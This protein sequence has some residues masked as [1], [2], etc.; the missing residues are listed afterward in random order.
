MNKQAGETTRW[1]CVLIKHGKPH[2]SGL[3]ATYE[4]LQT[5]IAEAEALGWPPLFCLVFST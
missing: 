4:T 2:K 5:A 3:T 1:W